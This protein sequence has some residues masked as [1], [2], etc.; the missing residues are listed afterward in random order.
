MRTRSEM[1]QGIPSATVMTPNLS[2]SESHAEEAVAALQQ[3]SPANGNRRRRKEGYRSKNGCLECRARKVKCDERRG[4]CLTCSR[5]GF[6]CSFSPTADASIVGGNK[7]PKKRVRRA[8]ALCRAQKL[9]C[10]GDLPRCERCLSKELTCVYQL[11][12]HMTDG[13]EQG[14]NGEGSPTESTAQRG[15]SL[16]LATTSSEQGQRQ[17]GPRSAT[18]TPTATPSSPPRGVDASKAIVQQHIDA[19]FQ[20]V[21]PSGTFNFIH[22]GSFLRSWHNGKMSPS[23]LRTVVGVAS[24]FMDLDQ[25][26]GRKWVEESER[27]VLADLDLISIP[28]L[29]ILLLLIF[30]RTGAAKLSAAWYLISLAAR[31]AHGLKFGLPTNAV[32]FT[33]QE[34]RRRLMWCIYCLDKLACIDTNHDASY[35]PLC[36]RSFISIQLPCDERSFQLEFECETH[37]L[38]DLARNCHDNAARLGATAY[39]VRVLDLW[40]QIQTF[41]HRTKQA[42]RRV[43]PRNGD[44]EFWRLEQ[45][46]SELSANLPPEMQDSERAVYIRANTQESN[47]YIMVQTWLRTC[48]CELMG[49]F[50]FS[51][52]TMVESSPHT[53]SEFVANCRRVL[54][55]N[56]VALQQFWSRIQATQGLSRRFF[57]TDWNIAPCVYRNT[58][59]FLYIWEAAPAL[60][61]NSRATVEAALRLNLDILASLKGVSDKISDLITA[62]NFLD[63]I[64][65]EECNDSES[66]T[67]PRSDPHLTIEDVLVSTR[68]HEDA[69]FPRGTGFRVPKEP[70]AEP[71]PFA[72]SLTVVGTTSRG[73][74]Q[75]QDPSA[76]ATSMVDDIQRHILANPVVEAPLIPLG[77]RPALST[78]WD[79]PEHAHASH[80]ALDADNEAM[81]AFY[82][83]VLYDDDGSTEFGVSPEILDS[84]LY[85]G[86]MRDG[87]ANVA[88][89]Y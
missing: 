48:W 10:S 2:T 25:G 64:S 19:F 59:A 4:G 13:D 39:L 8:C 30:D 44:A 78:P 45:E 11:G 6:S 49:T 22:R 89:F 24:R 71:Q 21:Y 9:R 16:S 41:C 17:S 58:Q 75:P 36:P 56:A 87:R 46:L 38:D 55:E 7:P 23:L 81:A 14:R 52:S 3:P 26:P 37:S 72:S 66:R 12:R 80:I 40:E 76:G 53:P 88:G 65:P 29:Q 61:S 35:P 60:L 83:Q 70:V 85:P 42:N 31:I 20:F 69:R 63:V 77:Q 54:I 57:V 34:C 18:P 51:T 62:A 86:S 82:A 32:P 47:V 5:L 67:L 33:N 84:L 1:V 50:L 68:H 79:A 73:Y 27:E 74:S 15:T 43:W 28:K